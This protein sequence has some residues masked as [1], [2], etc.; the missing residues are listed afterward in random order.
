VPALEKLEIIRLVEQ[1]HRP[2]RQT[3]AMI[4][5]PPTT[6]HRW[7]YL[8][9]GPDGLENH[10]PSFGRVW[11]RIPD[12]VRQRILDLAIEA[13]ELSPQELAVR[14][15]DTGSVLRVR[16]FRLPAAQGARPDHQTGLHR[17]Q[18]LVAKIQTHGRAYAAALEALTDT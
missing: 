12:D 8:E 17:G 11:N 10:K 3:L 13:P 15:T 6:F 2:V 1:S 5:I 9:A 18:A 7:W 14:F 4:G 16:S